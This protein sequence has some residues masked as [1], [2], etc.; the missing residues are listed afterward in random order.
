M[1]THSGGWLPESGRSRSIVLERRFEHYTGPEYTVDGRPQYSSDKHVVKRGTRPEHP[2]TF[3]F[4][5]GSSSRD[6]CKR[7]V[8]SRHVFNTHII[9]L[10]HHGSSASLPGTSHP[11]VEILDRYTCAPQRESIPNYIGRLAL[12]STT[13]S[14]IAFIAGGCCSTARVI[15]AGS[16]C[17]PWG[18]TTPGRGPSTLELRKSEQLERELE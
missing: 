11:T 18:P 17:S 5:F 10:C 4:V 9:V 7:F 8:E 16:S 2:N 15:R 14:A 13:V 6:V 3:K 1:R 12:E